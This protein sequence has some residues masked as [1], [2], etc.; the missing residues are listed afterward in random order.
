M[1]DCIFCNIVA[2]KLPSRKVYENEHAIAIM[3]AFPSVKGHVLVIP[4]K[5][6]M[7][8]F[9]ASEESIVEA[10]RVAHKIA[11]SLRD[12][13]EADGM[14][15][16]MNNGP[17]AFQVVEHPHIH[18][19]PRYDDDGHRPWG[20]IERSAEEMEADMESILEKLG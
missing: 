9:D 6:A 2:D 19:L 15:V 8:I 11:P 14:N 20:H 17:A 16:N 5:H 13:M 3:D 1:S 10:Y 4:K 18:M 12:A 7:N